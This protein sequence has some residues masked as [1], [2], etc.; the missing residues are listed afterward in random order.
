MSIKKPKHPAI[1]VLQDLKKYLA[2][3]PVQD[4]DT[5]V[6]LLALIEVGLVDRHNVQGA[7]WFTGDT[8]YWER[9]TAQAWRN[10]YQA[11]DLLKK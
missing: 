9:A 10:F 6:Q 1:E 3:H 4:P 5:Q 11:C 7:R 2:K 8:F